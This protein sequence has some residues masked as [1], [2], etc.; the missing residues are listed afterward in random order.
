MQNSLEISLRRI[1]RLGDWLRDLSFPRF[2]G[3]VLSI[4]LLRLGLHWQSEPVLGYQE[5][6]SSWPSGSSWDTSPLWIIWSRFGLADSPLWPISWLVLVGLTLVVIALLGHRYLTGWRARLL[7]LTVFSSGI[8]LRLMEGAGH[9]DVLFLLGSISLAFP[10]KSVWILA[11]VLAGLTNAEVAIVAGVSVI[12]TAMAF[13][14]SSNVK[15]GMTLAGSGALVAFG[16]RLA[17]DTSNVEVGGRTAVFLEAIIPSLVGNLSWLPLLLATGYLGAW[18]V[19]S[20]IIIGMPRPRQL[21]F[22]I[23]GLVIVPGLMTLVTLDGTRVFVVTS[24]AAFVLTIQHWVSRVSSTN[25]PG[26]RSFLS[27]SVALSIAF[28]IFV[29]VPEVSVFVLDPEFRL[30]PWQLLVDVLYAVRPEILP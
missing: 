20:L 27:P 26:G 4:E 14:D 10:R 23:S 25:I 1:S 6:A 12:L 28:A 15:K 7:V 8:P 13:R 5:W 22:L 21:I 30:A 24:A 17:T 19:V 11:A 9:Y 16:V 2:A 29:L 18:F 3:L